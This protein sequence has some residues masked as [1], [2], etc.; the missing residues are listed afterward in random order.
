MK[1]MRMRE[2]AQDIPPRRLRLGARLQRA[3]GNVIDSAQRSRF[4]ADRG[5]APGL[6]RVGG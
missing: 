1:K 6:Y 4:D 3:R 2:G 5:V